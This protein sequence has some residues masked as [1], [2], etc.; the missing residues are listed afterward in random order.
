VLTVGS[1]GGVS[2]EGVGEGGGE[3]AGRVWREWRGERC[4]RGRRD[5]LAGE[6]EDMR[7]PHGAVILL[8]SWTVLSLYGPRSSSLHLRVRT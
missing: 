5:D 1:G 2:R 6:A 3:I 8:F 7:Q 4:K